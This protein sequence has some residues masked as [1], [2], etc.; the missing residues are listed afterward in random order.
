[1][2]EDPRYPFVCTTYRLTEQWQTGTMTRQS[3]WLLEAEPQVYTEI[4]PELA[5][6]KG[7][8]NGEMVRISSPRGSMTAVA[9]VTERIRPFMSNGK[10]VHM[11]GLS[12][13]YGW[14]TPKDGGDSANLLSLAVGDPNVG[15]PETKAFMVNI[16]KA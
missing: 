9:M 14:L 3:S 15:I 2:V 7:I 1:M 10:K 8:K 12:W 4:D 5:K 6:A 13:Q 11:V 16:E